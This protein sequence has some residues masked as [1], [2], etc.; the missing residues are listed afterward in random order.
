MP[1]GSA[2]P[3]RGTEI[4]VTAEKLEIKKSAYLK[5]PSAERKRTAE[6]MTKKRDHFVFRNRSVR[7]P[8][9]YPETIVPSIK[10]TY[11]GSPQL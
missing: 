8:R 11:F 10:K 5:R 1:T 2:S 4:P 3:G 6:R 9:K 7:R